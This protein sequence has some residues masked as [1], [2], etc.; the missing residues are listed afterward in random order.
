MEEGEMCWGKNTT[1]LLVSEII[2]HPK[3][4]NT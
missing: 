3:F 2:S 1:P 4:K